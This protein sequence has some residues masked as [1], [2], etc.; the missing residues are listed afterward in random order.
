MNWTQGNQ[1][2]LWYCTYLYRNFLRQNVMDP[3][4]VCGYYHSTVNPSVSYLTF[5][6]I[7]MLYVC[8]LCVY[9]EFVWGGFRG[10]TQIIS[11]KWGIVSKWGW[12]QIANRLLINLGGSMHATGCPL[13]LLESSIFS[14]VQGRKSY[15]LCFL[16][17]TL[18]VGLLHGFWG[19]HMNTH[20]ERGVKFMSPVTLAHLWFPEI[21]LVYVCVYVDAWAVCLYW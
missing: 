12:P 3:I 11:A 8:V 14:S 1:I 17:L 7:N 15:L 20:H 13:A 2:S 19:H 6:L 18:W 4:K 16:F 10:D 9:V 21:H 5:H